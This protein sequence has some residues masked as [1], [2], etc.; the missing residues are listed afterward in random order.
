MGHRLI[1]IRILGLAALVCCVLSTSALSEPSWLK[2]AI[3]SIPKSPQ[4]KDASALLL[5][6]SEEVKISENGRAQSHVRMAVKLLK[7]SGTEFATLAQPVMSWGE[8]KYVKGWLIQPSGKKKELDDHQ[9]VRVAASQAAGY[10]DDAVVLGAHFEEATEGSIVAYEYDLDESSSWGAF[11]QQFVFQLQ[12]P[13]LFAQ[14][15]LEIPEGWTVQAGLQN[16]EGCVYEHVEDRHVWTVRNLAFRPD[17]P[18]APVWK[19]SS[20]RLRVNC[21]GP[22]KGNSVTF[23]DWSSAAH[24]VAGIM[25][26]SAIP[27]AA[28]KEFTTSLTAPAPT[29]VGKINLIADFV[30]SQIRYVAVEIDKGRFGPRHA[31]QTYGNRFGDCKDKAAL[32]RAM[33]AAIG[34]PSVAALA[35][36]DMPVDSTVVSPFQFDHC[37]VGIPTATFGDSISFPLVTSGKWVFF[38]PT[39]PTL[40]LGR[41]PLPEYNSLVLVANTET[42]N[43]TLLP[44]LPSREFRRVYHADAVLDSDGSVSAD[45]SIVDYGLFASATT[46][47]WATTSDAKELDALRERFSPFLTN[48][49]LS[50][51]KTIAQGDSAVVRFT[52]KATNSLLKSGEMFVLKADLV[53]E[54][55]KPVF[56]AKERE[57]PI[58]FGPPLVGETY[59]NWHLGNHWMAGPAAP[60]IHDSCAAGEITCETSVRDS[61]LTFHSKQVY[62]GNTLTPSDY[63]TAR[64]FQKTAEMARGVRLMLHAPKTGSTK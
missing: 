32:M 38:D 63:E 56:K 64:R 24:W 15:S 9:V 42:T 49:V 26:S 46:Y 52:V 39:D 44:A 47:S 54:D 20:R 14:F 58:Y 4:H 29:V 36:I 62:S 48:V 11:F 43:L 37:I 59:V 34:V 16:C 25:D 57:R 35:S 23:A 51:Y 50:D 5:F 60:L 40:S 21:T 7:S 30:R 53:H 17:E 61:I 19:L 33:L 8:A 1:A 22:S 45:V 31:G 13:V 41:I 28:V 55:V 10:Y 18:L 12:Q 2:S 6:A 3:D 27:D